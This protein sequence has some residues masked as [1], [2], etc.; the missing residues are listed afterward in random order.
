MDRNSQRG[1]MIIEVVVL[2]L[3]FTGLFMVA[4]GIAEHGDKAQTQFRFRHG[5]SNEA[6]R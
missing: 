3:M 5:S 2:V 6:S 1:Q 4:I